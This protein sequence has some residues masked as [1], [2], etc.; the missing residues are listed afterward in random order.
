MN[1]HTVF[2]SGCGQLI[3]EKG[4]M[5]TQLEKGTIS[6]KMVLKK[7]IPTCKR[8]ELDPDLMPHTRI[9]SKWIKVLNVRPE[10]LQLLGENMGKAS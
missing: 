9:N 8:M 6:P 7:P 2:H 3:F 4:A 5:N 1:L 10:T